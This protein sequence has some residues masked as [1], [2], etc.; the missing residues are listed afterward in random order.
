MPLTFRLLNT[1]PPLGTRLN[2]TYL[3]E[4]NSNSI[5]VVNI[6]LVYIG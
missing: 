6:V 1:F 3:F 2:N 5:I 4:Y